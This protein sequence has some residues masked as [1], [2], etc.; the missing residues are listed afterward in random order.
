MRTFLFSVLICICSASPLFADV[1][2][3][4]FYVL[5]TDSLK[6]LMA[7]KEDMESLDLLKLEDMS[8]TTG[9]FEGNCSLYLK[10]KEY[11]HRIKAY[12]DKD[13]ELLFSFRMYSQKLKKRIFSSTGE[14]ILKES[15]TVKENWQKE[16]YVILFRKQNL[17][18]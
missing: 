5:K 1:P 4:A 12:I 2:V 6:Q 13:G 10:T 15:F 3:T 18:R 16:K 17:S 14:V 11:Q 8:L 7:E 9:Y